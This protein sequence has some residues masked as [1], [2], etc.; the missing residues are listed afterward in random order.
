MHYGFFQ[1]NIHLDQ[2]EFR[3]T[4]KN[5]VSSIE[6]FDGLLIKHFDGNFPEIIDIRN[7][8]DKFIVIPIQ[9]TISKLSE[10]FDCFDEILSRR[11]LIGQYRNFLENDLYENTIYLNFF[12][13]DFQLSH[14]LFSLKSQENLTKGIYFRINSLDTCKMTQRNKIGLFSLINNE[15]FKE[16]SEEIFSFLAE[17]LRPIFRNGIPIKIKGETKHVNVRISFFSFDSKEAADLLGF[18]SSFNHQ[19]CCR[20]CTCAKNDFKNCSV[21]NNTLDHNLESFQSAYR[22]ATIT[23]PIYGIKKHSLLRHWEHENF[24]LLCPPCIDHD[25]FEGIGKKVFSYILSFLFS[26]RLT[27]QEQFDSS[28]NDSDSYDFPKVKLANTAKIRM[29]MIESYTFGRFYV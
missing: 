1:A 14:P 27:N 25:I 18:V 22:D 21:A 11:P 23:D 17:H 28:L 7:T 29:I 24:P 6:R 9:K 2:D 4:L 3:H 19:Y 16:H 15:V 8:N 20:F 5:C 13:D 12:S 26:R 10:N